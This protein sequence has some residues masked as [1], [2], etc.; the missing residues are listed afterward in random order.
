MADFPVQVIYTAGS[1]NPIRVSTDPV[2]VPWQNNGTITWSLQGQGAAWGPNGI[3]FE[4]AWLDAGFPQ[5]QPGPNDTYT[6]TYTNNSAG[7]FKY[8]VNLTAGSLDPQVENEPPG[9]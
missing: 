4:Q 9:M 1:S 6:V 3:Q 7:T 2:P 5:A 8:D